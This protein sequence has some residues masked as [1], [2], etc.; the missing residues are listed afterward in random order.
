M[1]ADVNQLEDLR[2]ILLGYVMDNYAEI[3]A[4]CPGTLDISKG[5]ALRMSRVPGQPS[6]AR[7]STANDGTPAPH[8]PTFRYIVQHACAV[9]LRSACQAKARDI[10]QAC[11]PKS[12]S[13]AITFVSLSA[14][15]LCN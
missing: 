15:F 3:K 11:G 5:C 1:A 7:P 8:T 6:G 9:L 4:T 2:A 10:I 13:S 14:S 12:Y